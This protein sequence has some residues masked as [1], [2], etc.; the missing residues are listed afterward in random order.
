MFQESFALIINKIDL[1]SHLNVNIEKIKKDALSL[2]SNIQILEVS[3]SNGK[4]FKPW[5]D[6]LKKQCNLI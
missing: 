4:G 6:Y 3:C 5:I 2:N 1:L